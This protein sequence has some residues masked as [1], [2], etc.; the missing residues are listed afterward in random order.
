METD[1]LSLGGVPLGGLGAIAWSLLNLMMSLVALFCTIVLVISMMKRKKTNPAG[2]DYDNDYENEEQEAPRRNRLTTLRTLAVL[3]GL[4][5]G[6]L[7]LILENIRLPMV[8]VT[9]W[10]PLI[11]AFFI[12]S[13]ALVIV[14]LAV[15]GRAKDEEDVPIDQPDD[16]YVPQHS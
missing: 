15:K 13:M 14:H 5:P 11:G 1:T 9:R 8:W 4:I 16:S 7:F 2:D 6:I 3:G 10:T 12:I